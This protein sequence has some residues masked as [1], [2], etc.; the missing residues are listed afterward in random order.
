M[1]VMDSGRLEFKYGLPAVLYFR[2][3][4][5][6]VLIERIQITHKSITGIKDQG[7]A[8][9]AVTGGMG[10]L[11]V[12]TDLLKK[13]P[14]L[15]C[16]YK[17]DLLIN[18]RLIIPSVFLLEHHVGIMYIVLLKVTG[19]D[20]GTTVCYLLCDSHMVRMIM[21]DKDII[22]IPDLLF[23][24]LHGSAKIPVGSC[25]ACIK[26][27]AP[28]LSLYQISVSLGILQIDYLHTIP[29]F[30]HFPVYEPAFSCLC[31]Y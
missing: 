25:P 16:S 4:V 14:A 2:T 6:F 27:K 18:N 26:E 19:Y 10:D 1:S 20:P 21:G 31:L 13:L 11:T 7:E 29:R 9:I 30:H 17:T 5:K 8:V 23:S 28:L 12:N 22:D 24:L 3:L 15:V